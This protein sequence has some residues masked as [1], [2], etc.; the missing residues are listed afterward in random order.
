MLLGWRRKQ[1]WGQLSFGDD[2][3]ILELG[4]VDSRATCEYTKKT[5]R[6][7]HCKMVG[8]MLHELNSHFQK[9]GQNNLLQLNTKKTNNASTTGERFEQIFFFTREELHALTLGRP[10]S[11]AQG[12]TSTPLG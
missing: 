1:V 9:W 5:H 4:S 11:A 2:E 6:T 7:V 3:N 8:F 12:E 10:E